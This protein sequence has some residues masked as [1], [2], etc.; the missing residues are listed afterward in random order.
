MKKKEGRI[1]FW[2][3]IVYRALL[4]IALVLSILYGD[5]LNSTL[6]VITLA[7]TFIPSI[8]E[9]KFNVVYPS[10]FE[11]MV[12]IF[13]FLSIIL[14]SVLSFYDRVSWWDLFMHMLSGVIIALIGFSL[15]YILNRSSWSK[16]KLSRIFVALF[17]LC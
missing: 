15:V 12:M 17:S 2:F 9:R 11:I 10:E 7:M 5:I 3:Y 13:I 16:I 1:R 6:S 14:G 4:I 8:V